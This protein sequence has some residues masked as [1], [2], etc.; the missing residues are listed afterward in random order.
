MIIINFFSKSKTDLTRERRE[1][2][3]LF[4]EMLVRMK[5]RRPNLNIK[6]IMSKLYPNFKLDKYY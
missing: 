3:V 2:I 5:K 4:Y 1:E 6:R